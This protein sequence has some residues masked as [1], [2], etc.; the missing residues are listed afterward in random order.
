[1]SKAQNNTKLTNNSKKAFISD[2]TRL[3]YTQEFFYNRIIKRS[4]FGQHE[5]NI[6]RLQVTRLNVSH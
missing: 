3:M 2:N 6:E 5:Y 1:M 4:K